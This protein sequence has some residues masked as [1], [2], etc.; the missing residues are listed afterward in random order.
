MLCLLR[1]TCNLKVIE[2]DFR[3]FK[4]FKRFLAYIVFK[5]KYIQRGG[6]VGSWKK[7]IEGLSE[8]VRRFQR[9]LKI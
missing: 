9:L 7:E 2:R 1:L 3:A 8:L 6:I 5:V 4:D